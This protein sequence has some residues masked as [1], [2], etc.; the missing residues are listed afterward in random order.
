MKSS[1]IKGLTLEQELRA[2]HIETHRELASQCDVS[3]PR[4]GTIATVAKTIAS[5]GEDP[6]KGWR[7]RDLLRRVKGLPGKAALAAL[8]ECRSAGQPEE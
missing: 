2:L 3:V 7:I 1:Y 8:R 4:T 5:W 6:E